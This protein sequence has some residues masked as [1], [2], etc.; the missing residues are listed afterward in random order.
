MIEK[1]RTGRLSRKDAKLAKEAIEL[2]KMKAIIA[3]RE[4]SLTTSYPVL[5]RWFFA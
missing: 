1:R 2:Q 4:A 3:A 5:P